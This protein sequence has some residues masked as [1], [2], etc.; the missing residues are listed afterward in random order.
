MINMRPACIFFCALFAQSALAQD[1][2]F[3]EPPAPRAGQTDA[4]SIPSLGDIMVDT[5]L[6]HI[7][8]WY[9]GRAE[10]WDLVKYELARIS[11]SLRKAA[12]T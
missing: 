7:K 6:R 4:L 11:E 5:Q 12:M 2:P 9:S 8:L 1:V 3:A 10:N